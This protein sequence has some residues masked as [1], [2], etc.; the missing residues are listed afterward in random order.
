MSCVHKILRRILANCRFW[1]NQKNLAHPKKKSCH[2]CIFSCKSKDLLLPRSRGR[3]AD[4]NLEDSILRRHTNECPFQE[5]ADTQDSWIILVSQSASR[6]VKNL[7]ELGAF[8]SLQWL[9]DGLQQE[10][11]RAKSSAGQNGQFSVFASS[12][13]FPSHFRGRHK[14][15]HGTYAA[16]PRDGRSHLL[17][18][19]KGVVFRREMLQAEQQPT[20]ASH[21]DSRGP[22]GADAPV[23]DQ[24]RVQ[25][26][27]EPDDVQEGLPPGRHLQVAIQTRL[28]KEEEDNTHA[29]TLTLHFSQFTSLASS[30]SHDERPTR[31]H[32]TRVA[33]RWRRRL[34]HL[35]DPPKPRLAIPP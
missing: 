27:V 3:H 17:P 31:H 15:A 26:G 33:T 13:K 35:A 8:S 1:L 5:H 22:G 19:S 32:F 21:R 4:G 11:G 25:G 23:V 30:L 24:G 7:N 20:Q 18:A 2:L 29:S 16:S 12:R 9:S 14:R 6:V 34:P 28:R 10:T